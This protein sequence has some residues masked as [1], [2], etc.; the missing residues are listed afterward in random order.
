MSVLYVPKGRAR[1]YAPLAVNHYSGCSHR[2][3]YCYVPTIPPYKFSKTAREDFHCSPH[4]RKNV[5]AQ[6]R[7]DCK[8]TWGYGQR[9][10]MSFTTDPYQP[11]DAEFRLTH[12]VI[13]VLH[14]Y[15]YAAQILTKGGS[16]AIYDLD[17][18]TK[19]DAFATTMTSL[20][21]AQS[22]K[23]EPCAASPADRIYAIHAFHEAGIPTW[24]SLEPVIDPAAAL[25]IIECLSPIVDLFKIGKINHHP[26]EHKINWRSFG[27]QAALL[28]ESLGVAYYLKADLIDHLPDNY[29][30]GAN[31]VT[32]A[33][34]ER[35]QIAQL[36]PKLLM[37]SNV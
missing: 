30:P 16:R 14:E 25:R 8:K 21:D 5:I 3:A 4:P 11:I 31:Q 28:C 13:E 15:G 26:L 19:Q 27:L 22:Q 29:Q 10:L 35:A 33:Q 37:R 32:V 34:I 24:V 9:V 18:F 6:L 17:V 23:W 2:C 12:Q 7:R 36:Q 20:S 1:E